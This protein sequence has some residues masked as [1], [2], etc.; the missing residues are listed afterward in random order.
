MP[1]PFWSRLIVVVVRDVGQG[2][3]VQVRT[4]AATLHTVFQFNTADVYSTCRLHNNL[5][6][7]KPRTALFLGTI[8]ILCLYRGYNF[9]K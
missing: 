9:Y 2:E 4:S 5:Y 3:G 8:C 6:L 1:T 7:E